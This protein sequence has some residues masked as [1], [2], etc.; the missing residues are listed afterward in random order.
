MELSALINDCKKAEI[1][2]QKKLYDLFAVRLFLIC[3]R[4]LKTDAEAEDMLQNGFLKIFTSLHTFKYTTDN[5][6]IAWMKKI[7]VNECLQE[8]RK[9]NNFFLVAEETAHEIVEE[10]SVISQL[11]TEEIFRFITSMPI[12]YRTVFNLYVIEGYNHQEIAD[13]LKITIGT[14][15][16]QLNKARKMLQDLIKN[17]DQYVS[18]NAR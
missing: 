10:N 7:M 2:A 15:K 5:A 8:L 11:S 14:S 6:F 4:Y 1:I 17:A 3:R 12:G 16:S 9:K 13:M 18:V